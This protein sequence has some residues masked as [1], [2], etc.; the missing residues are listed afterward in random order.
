MLYESRRDDHLLLVN[1]LNGHWWVGPQDEE[2][3]GRQEIQTLS[4]VADT[5]APPDYPMMIVAIKNRD[6]NI[7][8][9]YCFAEADKEHSYLTK[10]ELILVLRKVLDSFPHKMINFLFTGGEPFLHFPVISEAIRV[11]HG[12]LDEAERSRCR[13]SFMSNG[14]AF[15]KS[16][17]P[18]LKDYEINL[19]ISWMVPQIYMTAIAHTGEARALS[20]T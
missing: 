5:Q 10:D 9:T 18:F 19:G 12:S 13:F 6:C 2:D 7:D 11:F 4:A 3:E 1:P 15:K 8:C 16:M 14:T 20:K 17:L